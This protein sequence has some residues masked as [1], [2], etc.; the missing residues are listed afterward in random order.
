MEMRNRE[1]IIVIHGTTFG[2][3]RRKN[4]WYQPQTGEFVSKLDAELRKRGSNARC[5]AHCNQDNQLF[6]WSGENDWIARGNAAQKLADYIAKVAKCGWRCHIVAHSHGGNILADAI[7]AIF[8]ASEDRI[9]G[10]VVT[11]GTPFLDLT[12]PVARATKLEEG[13]Y[14]LG[15]MALGVMIFG[16]FMAFIMSKISLSNPGIDIAILFGVILAARLSVVGWR[17]RSGYRDENPK[18]NAMRH[19]RW[20]A[21]NSP[22]DEAWQIMH[23]L[24]S[25][26]NPIA[27]QMGFLRYLLS[28]YQADKRARGELYTRQYGT[29]RQHG[30]WPLIIASTIWASVVAFVMTGGLVHYNLGTWVGG[31][32]SIVALVITLALTVGQHL[33]TAF[34]FPIRLALREIGAIWAALTSIGTYIVRRASWPIAVRMAM[35]LDGFHFQVPTVQREPIYFATWAK[36]EDIEPD[37]AQSA[38]VKRGDWMAKHLHRISE[39]FAKRR[40][41]SID[42]SLLWQEIDSDQ[43]LVHSAYFTD[44]ICIRRIADWIADIR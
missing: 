7:P 26:R 20:L 40:V 27:V 21:L 42:I 9:L 1:T 44:E 4:P 32:F 28:S 43:T 2:R 37:V 14:V 31:S 33:L 34:L 17:G 6:T 19:P 35:G 25:D 13:A 22:Y 41:T 23:H 10:R 11:L 5:W 15:F 12:S 3:P 39:Q 38:M 24:K 36:Y 8:A 16:L 30:Y 29:I 18:K